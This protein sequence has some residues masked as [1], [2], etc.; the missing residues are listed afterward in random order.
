VC[1]NI[2]KL[3]QDLEVPFGFW[4][5]DDDELVRADKIVALVKKA[6]MSLPLKEVQVVPFA[7]HIGNLINSTA[8]LA[9]FLRRFTKI[10]AP[11]LSFKLRNPVLEDFEKVQ[12]I[13]RGSFGR[14]Y[15]VRHKIS[16]KYFALKVLN[17]T[18][19][20]KSN[21]VKHVLSE[22]NI[23]RDL[24]SSFVVSFVGSF[25]DERHL[26]ILMEYVIGGELFTQ[27]SLR[28]RFTNEG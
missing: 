18:D 27:L 24:N 20:I 28:K 4:V 25:Q 9:P 23:L 2:S 12:F 8:Y 14:V 16:D 7:S 11:S 19:V 3:F 6:S 5:G 13:G 15:L 21:E 22:R 17:K 10:V 26:Y 1:R